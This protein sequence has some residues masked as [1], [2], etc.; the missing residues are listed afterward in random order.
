MEKP[1]YSEE[2]I[3]RMSNLLIDSAQEDVKDL[4]GYGIDQQYLDSFQE[5]IAEGTA[6]PSYEDQ[7]ARVNQATKIKDRAVGDCNQ[8]GGD[9]KAR[10]E[11]KNDDIISFPYKRFREARDSETQM[12]EVMEYLLDLVNKHKADLKKQ[13]VGDE[14][15]AQGE[16]FREALE[17]AE[18]EQERLK[19][20]SNEMTQQRYQTFTQLQDLCNQIM[21][22]GKQVYAKN[23]SKLSRY[24]L[25]W[26]KI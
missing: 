12:L 21:I 19:I 17:Q 13:R 11:L 16:E 4:S 5:L 20:W 7:L 2:K 3:Q 6:L 1:N 18:K 9:L 23:P 24:D 14:F 25:K 26:S 10:I 15:I 8:W 22:A